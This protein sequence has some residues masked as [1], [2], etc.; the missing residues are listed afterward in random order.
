MQTV[1]GPSGRRGTHRARQALEERSFDQTPASDR[2]DPR[3]QGLAEG[4]ISNGRPGQCQDA[5]HFRTTQTHAPVNRE[6]TPADRQSCRKIAVCRSS[7]HAQTRLWLCSG[8]NLL[9]L[10]AFLIIEATKTA[11]PGSG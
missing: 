1:P 5:F 11:E 9:S 7:S 4:P 3:N 10:N 2:R 8:D 6:P